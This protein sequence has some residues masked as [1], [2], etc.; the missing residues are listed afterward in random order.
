[1]LTRAAPLLRAA[2]AA[3]GRR[4]AVSSAAVVGRLRGQQGQQ[5]QP[6]PHQQR[7]GVSSTAPGTLCMHVR[8]RSDHGSGASYFA[9]L[10]LTTHPTP[11]MTAAKPVLH[12][13]GKDLKDAPRIK[14]QWVGKDGSSV[15]TDGIVG[16]SILEAAHRHEIDLEGAWK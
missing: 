8:M 1:M 4:R 12:G 5:Q 16:E 10:N 14:V 9:M 6:S 15:E 13:S 2:G 7:R 3:C 11:P